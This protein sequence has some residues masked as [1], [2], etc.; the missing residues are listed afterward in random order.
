MSAPLYAPAVLR[1]PENTRGRTFVVGDIHGQY[2]M[3]LE[4]MKRARFD[5]SRDL[6]VAC[7]DLVDRGRGSPRVRR[8]LLNPFVRAIRGNH[9]DL[10]LEYYE[11]GDIPESM[12]PFL[13]GRRNGMTWWQDVA[14]QE[15][16]AILAAFRELPLAIEIDTPRGKVGIVHAEV[17]LGMDWPTFVAKLEQGDPATIKTCLWGRERTQGQV[18]EIIPGVDRVFSGHSI[19]EGGVRR[20]GNMFVVDT[21][22][23]L[24]ETRAQEERGHLTMAELICQT[25]PLLTADPRVAADVALYEAGLEPLLPFGASGQY[26]PVAA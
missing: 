4:A 5:R 1:L 23:F 20:Y 26:T 6:L 13:F 14:R 8:F 25:S 3:V 9:E 7:G 16:Q 10:F 21:G 11:E 22:A 17:P 24:R 12:L 2:D 15:R 19:Q 18:Q